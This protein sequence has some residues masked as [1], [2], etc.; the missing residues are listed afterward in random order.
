LNPKKDFRLHP[1]LYGD[2]PAAQGPAKGITLDSG[3]LSD[4]F[5]QALGWDRETDRP[6]RDRL[7][8]LGLEEVVDVLY[9]QE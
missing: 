6:S 3:A 2:P 7:I 9:P 5:Y 4:G 1:R 8:Q